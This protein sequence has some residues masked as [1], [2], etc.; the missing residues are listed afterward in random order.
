MLKGLDK[1]FKT[2]KGYE[3]EANAF[4]EL[5]M[6]KEANSLMGLFKGQTACKKNNIGTP[7]KSAQ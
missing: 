4:G 3:T 7:Q 6:S 2:Y 1:G 5:V